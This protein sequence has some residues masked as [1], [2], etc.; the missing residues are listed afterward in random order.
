MLEALYFSAVVREGKSGGD[1]RCFLRLEEG[2]SE[3]SSAHEQ[4]ECRIILI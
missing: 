2:K 4:H 3:G 1:A